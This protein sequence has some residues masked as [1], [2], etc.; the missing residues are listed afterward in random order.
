[1]RRHAGPKVSRRQ[2]LAEKRPTADVHRAPRGYLKAISESAD[3]Q[4]RSGR[5]YVKKTFHEALEDP[6]PPAEN[7][8]TPADLNAPSTS[9]TPSPSATPS[10]PSAPSGTTP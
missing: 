8:L 9:A 2:S 6:P 3:A 7:A 4:D 1:M 5:R 10:S